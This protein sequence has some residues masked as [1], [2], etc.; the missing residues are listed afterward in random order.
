MVKTRKQ[1]AEA[2]EDE[3]E[4]EPEVVVEKKKKS[5]D[6]KEAAPAKKKSKGLLGGWLN[7]S[8]L[9]TLA[10]CAYVGVAFTNFSRLLDPLNNLPPDVAISTLAVLSADVMRNASL[11]EQSTAIA[12]RATGVEL[13]TA[14]EPQ[15]KPLQLCA[16]GS[17]AGACG[18]EALERQ[19]TDAGPGF[20]AK[21]FGAERE[22]PRDRVDL[23]PMAWEALRTNG[24]LYLHSAI[25]N[26]AAGGPVVRSSRRGPPAHGARAVDPAR[27]VRAG[28][29]GLAA[30]KKR[31]LLGDVAPRL[32]S[33]GPP[34]PWAPTYSGVPGAMCGKWKPEAA[35]RVVAEFREWPDALQM[36]GMQRLRE[37]QPGGGSILKYA[38]P[39]Y[40]DEIG[41][42]SD[43]YVLVNDTIDALPLALSFAPLSFARWQLIARMEEGLQDQK[44]DFGFTD[45]DIDDV[46]RL[47]ADTQTWLLAVTM[48]ASVLHL[49]FEFLA[50]KSDIVVLAYLVDQGASLLVSVPAFGAIL[51]QAWKVEK[52]TGVR[53]SWSSPYCLKCHRL[54][55]LAEAAADSGDAAGDALDR[56]TLRVDRLTTSYLGLVLA[57]L[58]LGYACKTLVYD[59]HLGWYSWALGAATLKSVSHLPW[60][61]LCFRFVNTFIDDLFAFVIKMPM[62]HRVSCFR[63]DVVFVI[64]LYQRRIYKVD[65]AR[66]TAME[67]EAH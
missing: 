1:K 8:T 22:A 30:Q 48:L 24:T 33:L 34:A 62:M 15:K 57:P 35:V 21:L 28:A 56:E 16:R 13:S 43:K 31:K 10:A 46:R 61:L 6:K 66:S 12:W 65:A 26:E 9:A 23:P 45:N 19:R 27:Q 50:F 25:T 2:K 7:M 39:T 64:Y 41:L 60:K 59:A 20:L 53:L 37:R 51:I 14:T 3:A 67:D 18:R 49:L 17:D 11:Y 54:D 38:P 44:E 42:T 63:D 58:V 36:P 55:A 29:D 5:K 40:A 52:A 47:I 32:A 4:A